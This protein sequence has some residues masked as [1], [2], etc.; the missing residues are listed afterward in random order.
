M[1]EDQ[2]LQNRDG[3]NNAEQSLSS[4]STNTMT[5]YKLYLSFN[6]FYITSV[7][8]DVIFSEVLVSSS[9]HLSVCLCLSV[10]R[11]V[12]NITQNFRS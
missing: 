9:V 4:I 10:C 2:S 6:Y 7:A 11:F 3:K 8:K 12:I 1:S 5:N